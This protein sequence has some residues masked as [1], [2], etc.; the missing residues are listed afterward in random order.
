MSTPGDYTGPLPNWA[1]PQ[2]AGLASAQVKQTFGPVSTRQ[3]ASCVQSSVMVSSTGPNERDLEVLPTFTTT[4][5]VP[6]AWN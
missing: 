2:P 3:R 5:E 1:S 4:R 6:Q